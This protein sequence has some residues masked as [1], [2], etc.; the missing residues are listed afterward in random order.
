MRIAYLCLDRGV[1]VAGGKGAS[2]HV[3]SIT[4]ALAQ[5]GHEVVL[6]CANLGEGNSLPPVARIE[7]VGTDPDA[8]PDKLEAIFRAEAVDV[9]LER[10]SLESGPTGYVCAGL[11][12]PLVLEVNAP[13]VHE[14]ARYRGLREVDE[15]LAREREVFESARAITAVSET[16]VG[17]ARHVAPR[18]PAVCIANGVDLERF[19]NAVPARLT[20]DPHS[21]VIGFTGS[22]KAWH[23]VDDL[24]EAFATLT[25]EYPALRLVVAGSGPELAATREQVARRHLGARVVLPGALPHEQIPGVVQG[26][27]IGVAPYRPNDMF[28]FCPLKVLEYLGAGVPIVFPALGDLGAIVADAGVSYEPGSV[29]SLTQALGRLIVDARLRDD[30]ARRARLRAP[31]YSWARTAQQTEALLAASIADRNVGVP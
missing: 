16:L 7:E 8:H 26:F 28:Y 3:R 9:V 24:L 31:D 14:A 11:G 29:E 15:A 4:T 20:D 21:L 22:M 19:A 2:V 1:P 13:I 6:T 25:L 23:G 12:V 10:Y 30:L 27:D 18:T 5:R 17:Y